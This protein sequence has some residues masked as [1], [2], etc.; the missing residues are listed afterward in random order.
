[1]DNTGILYNCAIVL[2]FKASVNVSR[3][4]LFLNKY[5]SVVIF[6]SI[7]IYLL[8]IGSLLSCTSKLELL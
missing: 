7:P 8:E 3:K 1:M 4:V 5:P 6:V 2:L